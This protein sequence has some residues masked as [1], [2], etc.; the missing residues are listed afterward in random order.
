LLDLPVRP[1]GAAKWCL[2]VWQ[3]RAMIQGSPETL[4]QA[5]GRYSAQ[6]TAAAPG[7]TEL[8][9]TGDADTAAATI[10]P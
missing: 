7:M 9:K 8:E 3:N 6:H 2:R 10:S 1:V 4:R 5:R